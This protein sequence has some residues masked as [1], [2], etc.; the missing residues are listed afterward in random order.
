MRPLLLIVALAGVALFLLGHHFELTWLRLLSKP[1]P[2]ICLLLWL[3]EAPAG[4]YRRWIT[5]GLGLSL[6][7]DLL[8]EWPADLFVFGLGAFLLAHLAYLAA[9]LGDTRR[10]AP[11]DLLIAALAAGGM[12]YLLATA[13]GGLGQMLAPVALYSLVI[14]G[15]LWRALARVGVVAGASAWLAAGGAALFVLSDSLIGINRFVAPFEGAR[16]A[17]ILSYWLGQFGIATSAVL[18][19]ARPAHTATASTTPSLAE[20]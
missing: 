3:R 5:I 16:Y 14:G 15:M 9:Y 11:F 13:G 12:L 18:L 2:V 20:R 7:G 17:I 6:L 4:H 10:L 8:L 19:L 1:L